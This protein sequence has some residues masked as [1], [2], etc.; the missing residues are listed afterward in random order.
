MVGGQP[1]RDA[2]D[3]PAY[4]VASGYSYS[5]ADV[6]GKLYQVEFLTG[7]NGQRVHEL[8]RRVDYVMGSGRVARTYFTE[9]NGR[10]FQLPLTWYR[11]KGWDFSPGYEVNNLRFERVL[12]DRCVGCHASYPRTLP[13]LEGKYA[14]LRPGIGCER[15]HGLARSMC[16][17]ERQ[18]RRAILG[19]TRRS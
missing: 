10:L 15:C 17:R 13:Y 2:L 16:R 12:L 14:E 4:N 18:R 9:E 1:H 5:I 6:G 7:P 11:S 19:T 3:K 8:R